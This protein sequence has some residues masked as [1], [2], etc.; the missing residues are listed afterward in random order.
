MEDQDGYTALEQWRKR[1]AAGSPPSSPGAAVGS[2]FPE[3]R[4]VPTTAPPHRPRCL[5]GALTAAL[6]LSLVLCEAEGCRL[7]PVGWMLGRTKCYWVSERMNSWHGSREDCGDRGAA[8]AMPWDKDELDSLN[9]TLR[10]P[11]RHF[12]IGLSVPAPG[13]GW[14]WVNGSRPDWSRFPQD[15]GEGP[16][17]CGALKGDRIDPRA[18]DTGLQWICQTESARI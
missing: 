11:T 13:M 4:G 17:A 6:A 3:P 2:G 9:E 18:C 12:W 14:T 10:K 15:L 8:M 16:G 7:C 5:L 1:G